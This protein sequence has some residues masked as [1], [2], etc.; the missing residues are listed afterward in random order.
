MI[1]NDVCRRKVHALLYLPR[2][3]SNERLVS[4][5]VMRKSV[6]V[7]IRETAVINGPSSDTIVIDESGRVKHRHGY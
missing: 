1:K 6:H 5:T 7:I 2:V 3:D 4:D